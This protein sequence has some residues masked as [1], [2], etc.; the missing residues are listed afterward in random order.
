MGVSTNDLAKQNNLDYNVHLDPLAYQMI[1]DIPCPI[2]WMPVHDRWEPDW[3]IRKDIAISENSS[4]YRLNQSQLLPKLPDNMK[5]F[6]MFMFEKHQTSDWLTYMENATIDTARFNEICSRIDE[7]WCTAGFIH[8]AGKA[9]DE[10][11][12][13]FNLKNDSKAKPVYSFQPI[14]LSCDEN[15]RTNWGYTS[16][17]TNRYILK[18]EDLENYQGA[19]TAALSQLFMDL[20]D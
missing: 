5:K 10:S 8:A 18:V 4:F 14:E 11:G 7:K 16:Q 17:P 13:I 1:W 2:Y 6:Y 20:G 15:S 12:Q 19:M 3:E 9:V